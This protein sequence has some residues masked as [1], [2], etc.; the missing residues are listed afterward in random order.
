[1]GKLNVELKKGNGLIFQYQ[2]RVKKILLLKIKYI[3]LR[4]LRDAID[5]FDLAKL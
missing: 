4:H 1:M 2:N 5:E 3:H